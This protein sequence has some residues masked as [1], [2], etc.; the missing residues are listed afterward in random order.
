[1]LLATFMPGTLGRETFAFCLPIACFHFLNETSQFLKR[2]QNSFF[3]FPIYSP[4]SG[5]SASPG[6]IQQ[7]L[8][9]LG[10]LAEVTEERSELRRGP[11]PAQRPQQRLRSGAQGPQHPRGR[12]GIPAQVRQNPANPSG[13]RSEREKRRESGQERLQRCRL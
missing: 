10:G 9:A 5:P 8:A 13:A 2:E 1:M 11:S 4:R 6:A 12:A 7:S 3:A